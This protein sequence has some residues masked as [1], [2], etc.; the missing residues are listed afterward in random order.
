[1]PVIRTESQ[2]AK[3]LFFSIKDAEEEAKRVIAAAEREAAEMKESARQEGLSQGRREGYDAGYADGQSAGRCEAIEK[4]AEQLERAAEALTRAESEFESAREDFQSAVVRDC[5][6]LALAVARRVTRRQAEID[7]H[8]LA[9]N[10]EQAVKLV[11][12]AK[13]F[14][15]AL[16]PH[17]RAA[18]ELALAHL[19]LSYPAL[20]E[21]KLIDDAMLA[22]GGC[23]IYT[24]SGMIDA[25]LEGQLDRIAEQLL[26][27]RE[28]GS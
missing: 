10:L 15:I 3:P 23:R 9:A 28:E 24:E 12:G 2:I 5:V 7:P 19:K 17:D 14:R 11:V 20:E 13:N 27:V 6:E 16:H 21:A 25:D 8:V 18:M 26:P 22:R 4:H 1:M